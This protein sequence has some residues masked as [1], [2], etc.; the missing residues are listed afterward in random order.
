MAA[1]A[2]V[3]CTAGAQPLSFGGNAQ[4]TN[5]YSGLAQIQNVVKWSAFI[6]ESNPGFFGHYGA[7]L[8]TSNNVLITGV[9]TAG[10]SIEIRAF[11]GATGS[12]KYAIPTDFVQPAHGW[13]PAYQPVMSGSRLFF[14]GAGGSIFFIDNA[15]TNTP[16]APVRLVFYTDESSYLAN[17]AAYDSSVYADTPLTVDTTGNVYFGFRV[18][19]T[20]P[21]PLNTTVSGWAKITSAGVGSYVLVTD[22]TGDPNVN[23]DCHNLAPA[24]SNDESTLYVV[25][26]KTSTRYYGYLV[27][28]DTTTLATKSQVFLTDP[29]NGN[30]AGL[31]D[32]GTASPM[33]APDGDVY[34][35]IFGNPYNGS[36]GFLAHY[37]SDLSTAKT[38]GAFGWDFT[39]GIVPAS[40][41][42]SYTGSSSYLLF[43]KYNNYLIDG[44]GGYD[45]GDGVNMVA[46]IDPNATQT[47]RHLSAGGLQVMREVLIMPGPTPDGEWSSIP[48][49][50]REYCVNATCVNPE[51]GAVYFNSEDGRA[52]KWDL[53]SNSITSAIALTPGF[54]EPYVPTVI[55][56]DGTVFTLNGGQVFAIGSMTDIAVTLDSSNADVRK[57]VL[58]DN[59]TFTAHVTGT[60]PT[61]TGSVHF[62]DF[63]YGAYDGGLGEFTP[64]TVDLGTVPLDG[65]G[66]ASISTTALTAGGDYLGNHFVTASFSGDGNYGS[67]ETTIVQKVH[68]NATTT[69]LG[70]VANPSSFGQ[71]V[72]LT[73]T[74]AAVIG[75]SGTPTG[76]V[77][78]LDGTQVIGQVMLDGT[79]TGVF[80]TS[81]LSPGTHS[82]KAEYQSDTQFA[83]SSGTASQD[84][85]EGTTTA[86]QS[87]LNPSNVGQSVTFTATVTSNDAGAGTPTGSVTFKDGTTTI[88][89]GSLNGSG[90]ASM[91][92]SGLAAGN[93]TI[94]AYFTGSNGYLDSN[95]NLSQVVNPDTTAP[96]IP[97]NV[98]AVTGPL[99]GQ[100]SVS[101]SAST[102]VDDAVD[103]YEVWRSNKLNGAYSLVASPA[104]TSFVDNL[105]PKQ[106]RYYYVKAVDTHG[107]KSAAS[108]K[109]SAVSRAK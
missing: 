10:G 96:S 30:P 26:G 82:L 89:S 25:A 108:A 87:S 109:V 20:A 69:A 72:T 46:V 37:N 42:P 53:T 27:A 22:M 8:V 85:Q 61:P 54:G 65:S 40:M 73:A 55:G 12:L 83:Y 102:D 57:A 59:L 68:A 104:G 93:H 71:T 78:F 77:T 14:Q 19:G 15:D 39:P 18:Q 31:M 90:Q 60:G 49:A 50:V 56:P 106:T 29:R 11:D 23:R 5:V 32:D 63:T 70:T 81:A 33:V 7:P 35:G 64:V 16:S 52:Y 100:I 24:L 3:V 44:A 43:C 95:S 4:H 17:K 94:Y 21:A 103:H 51:S 48:G 45:E 99:K 84:V 86:I 67:V 80:T 66:N 75:G 47:E 105:G 34:L 36:R 62:V 107:N 91:N 41:V 2:S 101:W 13:T 74:V 6:D 79:G 92:I 76:V 88:G 38:F 97:Q 28:L 9:T 58:G 1:I 98:A